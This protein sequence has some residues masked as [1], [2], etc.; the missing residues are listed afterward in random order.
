MAN[1][2]GQTAGHIKEIGSIIKCTEEDSILGKTEENMKANI[3]T[4]RN[5]VSALIHGKTG[6]NTWDNGK[7]V[8]DMGE[9]K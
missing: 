4:T 7:I 5:T 9:E 3:N 2:S 6:G 1:T 8:N